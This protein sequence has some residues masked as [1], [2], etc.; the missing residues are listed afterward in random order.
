MALLDEAN[1]A[2]SYVPSVVLDS[3]Y[4]PVFKRGSRIGEGQNP[5]TCFPIKRKAGDTNIDLWLDGSIYPQ[6]PSTGHP[7]AFRTLKEFLEFV[8]HGQAGLLGYVEKLAGPNGYS[9]NDVR[10]LQQK[11]LDLNVCTNTE[12]ERL[13]HFIE[14][15]LN[16]L[17]VVKKRWATQVVELQQVRTD[18]MNSYQLQSE[19]LREQCLALKRDLEINLEAYKQHLGVYEFQAREATRAHEQ[20][21]EEGKRVSDNRL[22]LL[23]QEH[24]QVINTLTCELTDAKNEMVK[25]QQKLNKLVSTPFGQRSQLRQTR[26]L[27]QLAQKGGQR[28]ARISA[29]RRLLQPK[30]HHQL[31]DGN[32]G[33]GSR[34]RLCG[35]KSTQEGTATALAGMLSRNE[36]LAL[37]TMPILSFVGRRMANHYLEKIGAEIDTESILAA[38]DMTGVSQRGYGQIYKTIK[39]RV[40]LVDKD[41]KANFLPTPNKVCWSHFLLGI[42][43]F[44]WA[45]HFVVLTGPDILY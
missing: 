39:G 10:I 8:C 9:T 24:L 2:R 6:D 42:L 15:L 3:K 7:P 14:Y 40:G 20:A 18:E 36:A 27:D 22:A 21:L 29:I 25:L 26:A 43:Q 4:A 23:S 35:P 33:S 11:V 41:L 31:V 17:D 44:F 34:K 5:R 16:E 13:K 12:I 38:C 19:C 37:G 32:K 45:P 30:T 28:R 1:I